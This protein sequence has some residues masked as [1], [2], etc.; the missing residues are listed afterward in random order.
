MQSGGG[1]TLCKLNFKLSFQNDIGYLQPIFPNTNKEE[2]EKDLNRLGS[3]QSVI[4]GLNK[5]QALPPTKKM[6]A[7]EDQQASEQVGSSKT[8]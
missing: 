3:A 4:E 1:C 5:Q 2:L 7:N 6:K 8:G